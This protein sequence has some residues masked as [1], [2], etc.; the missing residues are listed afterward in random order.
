MTDTYEFKV[1]D[2]VQ[3]EGWPGSEGCKFR[4][5]RIFE[6]P[7]SEYP[8]QVDAVDVVDRQLRTFPLA[9]IRSLT[10]RKKRAETGVV[11]TRQ[12]AEKKCQACGVVQTAENTQLSPQGRLNSR[13]CLA[14]KKK[15]EASK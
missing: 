9:N 5:M 2:E 13:F 11:A 6:V 10:W 1:G 14:C 7:G 12:R 8:V 3:V 15:K 4:V